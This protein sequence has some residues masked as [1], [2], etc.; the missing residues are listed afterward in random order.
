MIYVIFVQYMNYRMQI[1][2]ELCEYH[3][4]TNWSLC[5][6]RLHHCQKVTVVFVN[7]TFCSPPTWKIVCEL[8]Q[9]L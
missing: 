7:N 8:K 3:L 1:M 5:N 6:K 2:Q 4:T 9:V